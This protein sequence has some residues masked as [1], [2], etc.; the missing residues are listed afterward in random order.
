MDRK[1]LIVWQR[2]SVADEIDRLVRQAQRE[3]EEAIARARGYAGFGTW[4]TG[5][6]AGFASCARHS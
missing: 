6:V 4:G 3:A 1:D 2:Q 5:T